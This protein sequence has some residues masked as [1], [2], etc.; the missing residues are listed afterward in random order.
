MEYLVAAV[1]YP[2]RT[3]SILVPI[4][5]VFVAVVPVII[6]ALTVILMYRWAC[7]YFG[8]AA[9][10]AA[11]LVLALYP[12][13]VDATVLG[14]FD[15]EM[16][17]P[18]LL[19]AAFRL[20]I[21]TYE[22]E[23]ARLPWFAVGIMSVLYLSV[24]R[25]GTFPLAIVGVDMLIRIVS[26]R[27]AEKRAMELGKA[28]MVMYLVA[29]CIIVFICATNVWGTRPIFSFNIISWFH[30]ALFGAAAAILFL[31]SVLVTWRTRSKTIFSV[32]SYLALA[33]ITL[34]L[35]AILIRDIWLGFKVVGG[36]N[37]WLDSI[38]QYERGTSIRTIL[39]FNGGL[40]FAMPFMLI[41]FR[42]RVFKH[43]IWLRFV[44]LWTLVMIIAALARVRYTEYLGLNAALLSGMAVYYVSENLR[45]NRQSFKKVVEYTVTVAILALQIPTCHFFQA[46]HASGSSFNIK[47]DIEDTMLWLRDN[48]PSAG[49]P[50]RPY[51]KPDYGV[52]ARW[53][54]SG[55]IE[56][57]AERPTLATSFGTETYGMEE[58]ARFFL[59][60]SEKEME[61]I[62]RKNEIR[63][64]IVDK[65]MGDLPMYARILG[66]E[67]TF[68]S[69]E[70]D[71]E[72]NT[73]AYLLNKNVFGLIVS[74]LFFA[75]G[76][77]RKVGDIPF[78]PVEG[79]R[80]VYESFSAADILGFPWE[81]KKLKVFEYTIGA[82]LK[83]RGIPGEVAAI[84]QLIETNQGR[85]FTF[86][87]EKVI[88]TDGTSSFT[89]MYKNK[90]GHGTTGAVSPVTIFY[91]S[92]NVTL[93]ILNADIDKGETISLSLL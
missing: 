77:T 82:T 42:S 36:G 93:S 30:A 52:L 90:I 51:I 23:G 25:G 69:E 54:Y 45:D 27:H 8:R 39:S 84:S 53:D 18:L 28:G 7:C 81:I 68:F 91:R 15:N 1:A 44:T 17:E 4:L 50:Y 26:S 72:R 70:W 63:Y 21:K 34:T 62:L 14:R 20:Y 47:G 3:L 80:L 61:N 78:K 66:Q 86:H 10:A 37:V 57:I 71:P 19:L 6:G 49:D 92:K 29:A 33:I 65:M 58:I 74:R 16:L 85:R 41:G 56:A 38:S 89:L 13:F 59:S 76:S 11:S 31:T 67:N 55:W 43:I 40:F 22:D 60:A 79:V 2:F 24:W 83:V 12:P 64:L 75:D 32:S 35:V 9:A 46:L 5:E 88:G 48:T 73:T 87:N